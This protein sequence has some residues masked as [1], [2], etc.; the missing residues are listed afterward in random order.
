MGRAPTIY[1]LIKNG[2]IICN[3]INGIAIKASLSLGTPFSTNFN[4]ATAST[5]AKL[6][7]NM[8]IVDYKSLKALNLRT[9]EIRDVF[10]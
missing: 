2:K 8:N 7:W 5:A 4:G 1:L 10:M 3:G 6:I 9:Y